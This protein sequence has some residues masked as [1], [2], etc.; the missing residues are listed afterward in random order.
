MT[1]DYTK[2]DY[3]EEAGAAAARTLLRRETLPTAIV[4][5]NDHAAVGLLQD[6]AAK[7]RADSRRL[8]RQGLR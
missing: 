4:V 6:T 1:G 5:P 3:L 7:R 8:V 2:G